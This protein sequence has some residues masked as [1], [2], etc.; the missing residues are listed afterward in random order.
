M[1]GVLDRVA[2]HG[3]VVIG[4]G[5]KDSAPMLY[6]G[7]TVGDRTGPDCDVAVDPVDGTT[8]LATGRSNAIAVLAVAP[9]G[10]MYDPSAVFYMDKIVTGAAAA[11]AVDIDAPVADNI[12]AVAHAKG[13]TAAAADVTVC[14]LDR[15]RHADLIHQI[16]AAGARIKL[17]SDGDVAGAV[18]AATHD[19]GVDLLLGVGGTPNPASSSREAT[20][21]RNT[22]LVTQWHH[23]RLRR[24]LP[25]WRYA[26][27]S[28]APHCRRKPAG[29]RSGPSPKR[30]A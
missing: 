28:V 20:V 26:S 16:R 11:A 30:C 15:P 13:G 10:S 9:R 19:T 27:P 29:S 25:G 22:W 18:M 7:E 24:D 23:R 2:T 5:E 12:A 21:L 4:E 8:L 14:V 1:R 6:N 17:I 3:V